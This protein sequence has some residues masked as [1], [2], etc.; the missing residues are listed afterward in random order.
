[1]HL[2]WFHERPIAINSLTGY[3][4]GGLGDVTAQRLEQRPGAQRVDW[5]HCFTA[6]CCG[7]AMNGVFVPFWYRKLDAAIPGT[8]L[9]AVVCKSVADIV[10]NGG[11]SNAIALAARGAPATEIVSDMPKVMLADC[12]AWGPYNMIAFGRIPQHVRPT[13][14]AFMTFGWNT[15]ISYVAADARRRDGGKDGE[16]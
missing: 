6:A 2:I 9:Q 10:V 12:A 16:G 15:Y 14:T 5:W 1:M 11:L 8:A 13:T 7:A 3:L 4:L